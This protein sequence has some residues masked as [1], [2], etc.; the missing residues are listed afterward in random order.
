[1][2]TDKLTQEEAFREHL[3][4]LLAIATKMAPLCQTVDELVGVLNLALENDAQVR[5]LIKLASDKK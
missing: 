3:A 1:M 4:D 2:A 5:I